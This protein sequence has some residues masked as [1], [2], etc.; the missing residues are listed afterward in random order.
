[1]AITDIIFRDPLAIVFLAIIMVG[2]YKLSRKDKE[3]NKNG[4]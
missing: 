3:A 4:S 1:M 2:A